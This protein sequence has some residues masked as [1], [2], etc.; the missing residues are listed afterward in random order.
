MQYQCQRKLSSPSDINISFIRERGRER[1]SV[2]T[3]GGEKKL[4]SL[5]SGLRFRE[6]WHLCLNKKI[7]QVPVPPKGCDY[8]VVSQDL[9]SLK[10]ILKMG[11]NRSNQFARRR[12]ICHPYWEHGGD[13][14]I[15]LVWLLEMI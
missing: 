6:R 15:G 3:S 12:G 11:P 4:F 10:K 1:D 7:T 14:S 5:V 9:V 13:T 8:S 2:P